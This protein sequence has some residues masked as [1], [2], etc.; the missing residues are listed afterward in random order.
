MIYFWYEQEIYHTKK[1]TRKVKS[2]ILLPLYI[3]I[4]LLPM[5]IYIYIYFS[6][7]TFYTYYMIHLYI[8][9]L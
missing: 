5:Y 4:H 3:I 1:I 6:I 9:Y 7:K 2:N 8:I